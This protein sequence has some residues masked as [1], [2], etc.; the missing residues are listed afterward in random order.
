MRNLPPLYE[1][2]RSV[3]PTTQL[4]GIP[5]A[6]RV[7]YKRRRLSSPGDTIPKAARLAM[8]EVLSNLERL[9]PTAKRRERSE[10]LG[11]WPLTFNPFALSFPKLVI[12]L[13]DR[14]FSCMP[15][16]PNACSANE[17]Y[18]P[19]R[20]QY[21]HL[22]QTLRHD[23]YNFTLQNPGWN[24]SARENLPLD[25]LIR[26]SHL[27][28]ELEA[29][30]SPEFSD[31]V[32]EHVSAVYQHWARLGPVEQQNEWN[33]ALMQQYHEEHQTARTLGAKLEETEARLQLMEARYRLVSDVSLHG[34]I[35]HSTT[36][37]IGQNFEIGEDEIRWNEKMRKWAAVLD[38]SGDRGV[39][40]GAS[41]GGGGAGNTLGEPFERSPDER[42][43]D[44]M[45]AVP[46]TVAVSGQTP[47]L[48]ALGDGYMRPK[49]MPS[50]RIGSA[51]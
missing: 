1:L 15:N 13:A 6:Q 42:G 3:P 39:G 25:G 38:E 8:D 50:I 2:T 29:L 30:T 40:Y 20:A 43:S 9:Q 36:T 48:P 33:L 14:D 17:L 19:G 7:G 45:D 24:R 47:T 4:P 51:V 31:K 5:S 22:L 44:G 32:I 28:N 12:K 35:S 27:P 46:R 11:R 16:F 26:R 34:A 41:G 49:E 10:E 21:E 18:I 37:F 23:F